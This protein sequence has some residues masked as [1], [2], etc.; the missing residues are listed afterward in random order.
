MYIYISVCAIRGG[1][2]EEELWYTA[3]VHT[4]ML[5]DARS[6]VGRLGCVEGQ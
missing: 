5:R 6:C 1:H 4:C 2:F 3:S